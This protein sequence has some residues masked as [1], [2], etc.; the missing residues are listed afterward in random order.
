MLND[1]MGILTLNETE[2]D[3]RSLTTNRPLASIPIAGR[4]RVIDFILSNMVNSGIQNIGI[5]TQSNSRSLTDHLGTGKPWDLNRKLDGLFL[6]NY[7]INGSIN[8]NIKMLINNMDYL[9]KSR[10]KNIILASS[11][12]I[13]NIDFN[14]AVKNHDNS[15]KDITV[16]YTKVNNADKNLI[17]CDVLNINENNKV[18]S[19]GKNIGVD[20]K[21]NISME[22]FIMKKEILIDLIYKCIQTGYYSTL[23]D[24]IYQNIDSLN[25]NAYEFNGYIECINSIKR[26]YIANMDMLNLKTTKELFFKNGVI[27]TKTKDEAPTKYV[28]G[29]NVTNSLIANGCIIEGSVENSI[30]SRHVFIHKNAE[31]KNSIILQNCEIKSGAKLNNVIIDKNVII[32]RNKQLKGTPEFPLVIEKKSLISTYENI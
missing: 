18:I 27:Y 24:S 15:K 25:V 7:N 22:M 1:Y 3:I 19:V 14:Q 23:K 28:N 21:A 5:F 17:N 4:Y 6:F 26:Y 29:S 30:L 12:M 8:Y 9:Y 16:I 31:V 11:Y 13:C 10:Q 2:T 32:N 20:K